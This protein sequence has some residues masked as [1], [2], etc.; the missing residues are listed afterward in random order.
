MG[1]RNQDATSLAVSLVQKDTKKPE[2]SYNWTG[3]SPKMSKNI[4]Q[5]SKISN[6]G[7]KIPYRLRL[8]SS[9]PQ[10]LNDFFCTKFKILQNFWKEC[11]NLKFQSYFRHENWQIQEGFIIV[12]LFYWTGR[13]AEQAASWF[14]PPTVSLGLS[15][16]L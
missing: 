9:P 11:Y 4:Q 16:T 1:G 6:S 12:S 13:A 3:N 14:L 2:M 7:P 5:Y 15:W 8:D 10:F